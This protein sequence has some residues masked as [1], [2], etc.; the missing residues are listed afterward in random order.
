MIDFHNHI[1]PKIDDGSKNLDMSIKMIRKASS[2]GTKTIINTVHF[3]H[4][5]IKTIENNYGIVNDQKIKLEEAIAKNNIDMEILSFAE[6]Y[7]APNL[8]RLI[9]NEL[10]IIKEKYMLI[11]FDPL[12]IPENH[13]DILYKLQ[14]RG[15]TPIIA[16]PERYRAIQNNIENAKRWIE[17]GYFLQINS[18]SI[19]GKFG[20]PIMNTSLSLMKKGYCHLIGSD[21]HNDKNRNFLL[22]DALELTEKKFGLVNKTKII[23]NFNSLLIGQE[24]ECI[25]PTKNPSFLDSFKKI[26]NK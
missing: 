12:F 6:V 17:L 22:K 18:G 4:P 3:Q 16:H 21:A 25:D 23:S 9:D 7:Y 1:I 14:L 5:T 2:E 19:I 8:H 24:L 26:F 15:I 10:L 11:E 20:K 13:E